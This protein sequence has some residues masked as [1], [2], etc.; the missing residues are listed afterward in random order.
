MTKR[1]AVGL[2]AVGLLGAAPGLAAASPPPG[3]VLK[4]STL[5]TTGIRYGCEGAYCTSFR[6]AGC[7]A[8]MASAHG[9][10]TSIV[11]VR[12]LAG[13]RLTFTWRDATAPL[14]ERRPDIGASLNFY[15]VGSCD[16]PV[17]DFPETLPSALTLT[18]QNHTQ[19]FEIPD[20][21]KWLIVEPSYH[22]TA[23]RWSAA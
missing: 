11:D 10:T 15:A 9:L 14:T 17:D 20:G 21:T 22:A 7:P 6:M 3:P 5:V 19:T 8:R 1:T 12:D 13:E 2:L 16:Y 23:A 18:T 4:G